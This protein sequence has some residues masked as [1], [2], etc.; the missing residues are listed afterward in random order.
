MDKSAYMC[1]CASTQVE[2]VIAEDIVRI[3][4][5]GRGINGLS[6]SVAPGQCIGILGPNG[7]GKTTLTRLVAGLD[8]LD[9]GR[10]LVLGR[11]AYAR[12]R[13]LR[14]RCGVALE[15]PAHW[16]A[17]SGRQNLWFFA[18]QYGLGGSDLNAHLNGLLSEADLDGQA[19][20]L[21]ATYSFGMRRKLGII[22]AVCADPDLLI[23][24]EPSAGTDA[25]FL[26]RLIQWIRRRCERGQTTWLADN[27]ADWLGRAATHVVLLSDGRIHAQGEVSELTGSIDAVSH[28]EI[29]LEQS[30]PD[31][32]SGPS[33]MPGI[34][35]FSCEANRIIA[36]VQGS[37]EIPIELLRWITSRGGR[38]R[39][40]EVRA[41]TLYEALMQRAA[42]PEAQS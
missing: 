32:S 33:Q 31:M 3:H 27:D 26:E 24:D 28:I 42:K 2:T 41:I 36:E 29:M 17:L 11:P 35:L 16:E 40:M 5:T 4:N 14:R 38:V 34:H 20:D 1:I 15:T 37:R 7:S 19:D 12:P 39:S 18:R 10:L 25:A 8:R 30:C 21:V 22:E 6:M 9:R 13:A 23:L